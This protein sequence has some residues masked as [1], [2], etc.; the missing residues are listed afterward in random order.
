MKACQ[1]ELPLGHFLWLFWVFLGWYYRLS[2]LIKTFLHLFKS[3]CDIVPASEAHFPFGSHINTHAKSK[4]DTEDYCSAFGRDSRLWSGLL[5]CQNQ[6]SF[7]I[8]PLLLLF[9]HKLS[10]HISKYKEQWIISECHSLC[11]FLSSLLLSYLL[12]VRRMHTCLCSASCTS[13]ESHSALTFNRMSTFV[14]TLLTFCPPAPPLLAKLTS[15]S[16]D[17]ITLKT[18]ASRNAP[19]FVQGGMICKYAR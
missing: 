11:Q 19:T 18:S 1:S 6:L 17:C 4:Q 7:L 9:C 5:R 15:T 16:S 13:S 12:L 3:I 2:S 10:Q 8:D 14:A